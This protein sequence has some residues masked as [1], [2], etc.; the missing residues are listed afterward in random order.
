MTRVPAVCDRCGA[1]FPSPIEVNNST[2]ITFS[3]VGA[4]PCPRC[5]GTGHVPDGTYNFIANAIELLGGP[6]RSKSDLQ[7]LAEML[8]A[9]QA[10]GAS[11]QEVKEQVAK[12]IPELQSLADAL[13]K[14]R[15]ELYAFITI[16]LTILTLVLT[17]VRRG[18]DEKIEVSQVINQIVQV[19]P[20]ASPPS[21]SKAS[22]TPKQPLGRNDPCHC[23][24]GKKY[25]KCHGLREAH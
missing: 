10:R 8:R 18:K 24:S 7:R 16:I 13:P 3:G 15:S 2:N 12:E 5:G 17:E 14:T 11:A 4:G 25:K 21:T 22:A 9:A 1:F 6:Q 20:T 19:M 23:V